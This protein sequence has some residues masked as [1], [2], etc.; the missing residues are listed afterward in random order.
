[1][2]IYNQLLRIL[3]KAV[4]G[5]TVTLAIILSLG[6][7]SP[8]APSLSKYNT[9]QG[10]IQP[11]HIQPPLTKTVTF[12]YSQEVL[13]A[14]DTKRLEK[15]QKPPTGTP[16][17]VFIFSKDSPENFRKAFLAFK[18]IGAADF[19]LEEVKS[20]AFGS[21]FFQV[22]LTSD[23]E[24]SLYKTGIDELGTDEVFYQSQ[25]LEKIA[26]QTMLIHKG[27]TTWS[28]TVAPTAS[29]DMAKI[30]LEHL[31]SITLVF[32]AGMGLNNDS[33]NSTEH[34]IK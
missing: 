23:G 19:E 6:R 18:K 28:L 20:P 27:N 5:F 10:N 13:T 31:E 24:D 2:V 29:K 9:S 30:I 15:M 17:K 16:T 8:V 4:I 25:P 7:C 32:D 12:S 22:Q 26:L 34:M 14:L 21:A 33:T 11:A 1:M 3:G